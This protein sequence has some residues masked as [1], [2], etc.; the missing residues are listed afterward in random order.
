MQEPRQLFD[1]IAH[2]W[3]LEGANLEHKW[4]RKVTEYFAE[5]LSGEDK[6]SQQK[7][8]DESGSE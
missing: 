1:E 4:I 3:A 8:A 2:V 6:N 7:Q 5:Q